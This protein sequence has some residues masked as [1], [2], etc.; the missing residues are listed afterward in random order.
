MDY[1]SVN[2]GL[3]SAIVI[4]VSMFPYIKAIYNRSLE[5][6]VVSTW[7]LWVLI[8]AL[9][10]VTNYDA[11]SRWDTTLFPIFV[12]VVN[13]AL[14]LLFALRYGTYVW[15]KIDTLCVVL[16]VVTIVVWQTTDSPVLGILGGILADFTAALPQLIKSWREPR[17]EPVLPWAMFVSASALSL[18]AVPVWTPAYFIF[19]IYMTCMS[20]LIT[21]PLILSRMR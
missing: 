5:R 18:L 15:T 21:L 3:I 1:A 12:G 20:G 9:L 17:D 2:W 7:A 11:G 16:C 13:P 19:P 6:P 8:G 4:F 10:F 14:V